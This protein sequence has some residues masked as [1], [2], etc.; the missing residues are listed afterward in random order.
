MFKNILARRKLQLIILKYLIYIMSFIS[1]F[2]KL[3]KIVICIVKWLTL[4]ICDHYLD[5]NQIYY[6]LLLYILGSLIQ[7][8]DG[9]AKTQK[10][11]QFG[12]QFKNEKDKDKEAVRQCFLFRYLF[13]L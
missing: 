11:R 9:K 8:I 5:R 10:P 1:K 4:I 2:F 12:H 6:T 3:K 7:M 13:S